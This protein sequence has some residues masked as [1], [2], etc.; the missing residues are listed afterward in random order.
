MI[1]PIDGTTNFLNKVPLFTIS[2]AYYENGKLTRS[3]V[4]DVMNDVYYY[5][6]A[7][8][9]A[10]ANQA[11]LR[12]GQ[13]AGECIVVQERG[14]VLPE[15]MVNDPR[16]HIRSIGSVSLGLCWLAEG[17]SHL[18]ITKSARITDVAGALLIVKEAGGII[19]SLNKDNDEDYKSGMVSAH[20][21]LLGKV[22]A[23]MTTS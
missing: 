18:F 7:G 23:E 1:D 3:Y 10:F 5:A 4:Y 2:L 22:L 16:V 19:K 15:R 20:P 13:V 17:K 21:T 6:Q 8:Q 14:A 11:R 12:L 9:G